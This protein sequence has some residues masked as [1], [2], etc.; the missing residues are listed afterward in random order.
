MRDAFDWADKVGM[1][2]FSES[3]LA[4]QVLQ[5]KVRK[6][7][8]KVLDA[9]IRYG[10]LATRPVVFLWYA[11][12]FKQAGFEGHEALT[13]AQ[14][15]TDFAMVNYHPDERPMLYQSLGVVGSLMGALST[16]KHN[17]VTQ[18]ITRG[19]VPALQLASRVASLLLSYNVVM[20]PLFSV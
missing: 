5:S 14:G 4:H 15:A 10:E 7:T 11:D 19:V 8:D 2:T 13:R 20:S 16:Y 18:G 3:E 9:S 12:M 17:Y 6:A 1:F